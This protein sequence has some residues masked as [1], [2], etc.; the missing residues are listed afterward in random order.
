MTENVNGSAAENWLPCLMRQ[1]RRK[2][3]GLILL[4]ATRPANLP[5]SSV[6]NLKWSGIG[7]MRRLHPRVLARP[8]PK[9]PSQIPKQTQAPCFR[10]PNF[11]GKRQ[12]F[13]EG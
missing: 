6:E 8:F 2:T 7:F 11:V 5:P 10:L 12:I 1:L 3:E 13:P 4:T 9:A